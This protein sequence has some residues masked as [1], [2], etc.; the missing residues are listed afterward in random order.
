MK[1]YVHKYPIIN[2]DASTQQ[3]YDYLKS[4]FVS[5]FIFLSHNRLLFDIKILSLAGVSQ[6]CKSYALSLVCYR[7]TTTVY[8]SSINSF[9]TFYYLL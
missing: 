1:V 9:I 2:C 5:R 7:S 3:V 8:R 6:C 4:R